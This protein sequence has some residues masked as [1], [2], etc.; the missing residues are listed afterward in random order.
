MERMK[1]KILAVTILTLAGAAA[2]ADPATPP[3]TIQFIGSY[4]ANHAADDAPLIDVYVDPDMA[5]DGAIFTVKV[6]GLVHG[7]TDTSGLFLD[8]YQIDCKY[9][10]FRIV[11]SGDADHLPPDPD[12]T[13]AWFSVDG[14]DWSVRGETLLVAKYL[15][16]K[17]R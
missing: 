15:C 5:R 6:M 17:P 12:M 14:A 9:N 2:L 10:T 16:A 4:R 8:E 7:A 1:M 13:G 11:A 3:P